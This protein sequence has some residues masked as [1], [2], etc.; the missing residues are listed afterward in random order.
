ML[1]LVGGINSLLMLILELMRI[2]RASIILQQ[3]LYKSA[4]DYSSPPNLIISGV[5]N[6]RSGAKMEKDCL[7]K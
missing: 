7:L 6:V 4:F 3:E 1:V 5:I 2:G